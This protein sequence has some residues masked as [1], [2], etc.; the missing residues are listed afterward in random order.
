MADHALYCRNRFLVSKDNFDATRQVA[1]IADPLATEPVPPPSAMP[2]DQHGAT[3]ALSK[4]DADPVPK[5][6]RL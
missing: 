5:G 4:L 3:E 1:W 2:V 6:K